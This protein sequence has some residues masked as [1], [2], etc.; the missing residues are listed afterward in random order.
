MKAQKV[1][2]SSSG[3]EVPQMKREGVDGSSS[4]EPHTKSMR[5]TFS[6]GEERK[7]AGNEAGNFRA[8]GDI[9]DEDPVEKARRIQREK[10]KDGP[11][12]DR[13]AS[14]DEPEPKRAD[15][16]AL[17]L[18]AKSN[19]QSTS[20]MSIGSLHTFDTNDETEG[21]QMEEFFDEKTWEVSDP[22]SVRNARKE[23][24]E[25]MTKIALYDEVDEGEA[26]KA[27]GRAPITAK[28]V[29]INK[30]SKE[31]PDVR[32]R[33]VARDF[34]PK[35][36]KREWDVFAAMPPLEAKKILLRYAA[37]QKFPPRCKGIGT[38]M[39]LLFIDAKKAHLNGI[40]ENGEEIFVH[41]R[42]RRTVEGHAGS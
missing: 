8:T 21:I 24:V 18:L 35:G 5:K 33:L 26:W 27:I 19:E 11:Q 39:K 6:Q 10:R 2:S 1:S 14:M 15:P 9:P 3:P 31:A 22:S 25:F 32:C 37:L 29:D 40:V 42:P 36:A 30:G 16:H 4:N 7:R 41:S 20:A 23:E 28:W 17:V 13:D 38:K 34:K 12:G